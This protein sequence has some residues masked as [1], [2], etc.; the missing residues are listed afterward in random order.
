MARVNDGVFLHEMG[1]TVSQDH[2]LVMHNIGVV[3]SLGP[4][5]KF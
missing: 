4:S 2:P 1:D 5:G 3:M